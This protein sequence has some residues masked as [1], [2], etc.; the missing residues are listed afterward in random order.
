MRKCTCNYQFVSPWK[1][2]HMYNTL[3]AIMRLLYREWHGFAKKLIITHWYATGNAC[4]G[5]IKDKTRLHNVE[6]SVTGNAL[7]W[8][9]FTIFSKPYEKIRNFIGKNICGHVYLYFSNKLHG[10]IKRV[11]LFFL[12]HFHRKQFR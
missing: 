5:V 10:Q 2:Y 4:V 8:D 9:F 12:Q 6:W 1:K 3:V 11:Q 7:S